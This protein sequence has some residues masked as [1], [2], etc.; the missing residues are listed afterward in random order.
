MTLLGKLLISLSLIAGLAQAADPGLLQL[1][2]PDATVVIGINVGRVK[3]SGIAQSM[4]SQM[5]PGDAELKKWSE[6]TGFDPL[7]DLEEVLIAAPAGK[8]QGRGL[9]L[10]RGSFEASRL[11]ELAKLGDVR[12]T[13]FQGIQIASIEQQDPIALACLSNS[14]A[15]A[16]DPESVRAAIARRRS[17]SRL[18]PGLLAKAN[19][20]SGTYDIWLAAMT[21]VS[22]LAGEVADPKLSGMAGE[23]LK[24]IQQASGGIKFG[25]KLEVSLELVTTSYKDALALRD[26]LKF[27][28]GL[29]LTQARPTQAADALDNLR[30]TVEGASLKLQLEIPEQQLAQMIQAQKPAKA[31]PRPKPASGEIVIHSTSPE[32]GGT[33][34]APSGDTSV[35]RLPAPK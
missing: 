32:A 35:V 3:S 13:T 26:V 34:P 22:D 30:L 16:G 10:M 15:V 17:A 28:T 20:L 8:S 5:Q 33:K 25:T 29:A 27:F 4:V 7:R 24:S 11:V 12:L 19:Q 1:V 18:N 23:I 2:M 9:V 6:L 14:L 31:A 21:P